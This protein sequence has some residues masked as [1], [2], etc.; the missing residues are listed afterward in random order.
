MKITIDADRMIVGRARGAA[1]SLGGI[2]EVASEK[3]DK[4]TYEELFLIIR[5]KEGA[6]VVAGEL[7]PGF[8]KAEEI[9]R[10]RLPGFPAG[11]RAAAEGREAGVREIIWQSAA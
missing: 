4:I 9:L 1:V 2:V 6:A 8:H 3:V 11:W 5:G 10:S 7:D